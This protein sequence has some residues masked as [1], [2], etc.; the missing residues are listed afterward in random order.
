MDLANNGPVT[1]WK[2]AWTTGIKE[3]KGS[4]EGYDAEEFEI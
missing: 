1:G 3:G 2:V 4:G